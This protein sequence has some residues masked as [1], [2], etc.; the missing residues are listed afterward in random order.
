MAQ[1]W[2]SMDLHLIEQDFDFEIAFRLFS[3]TKKLG[4]DRATFV[5]K[6]LKT[7]FKNIQVNYCYSVY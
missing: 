1:V 7:I 5:H 2:T 3:I 4:L 6:N